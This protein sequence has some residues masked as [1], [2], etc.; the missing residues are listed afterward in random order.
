[1][2][3]EEGRR[4]G[5]TLAQGE[6]NEPVKHLCP[7]RRLGELPPHFPSFQSKLGG[8]DLCVKFIDGG[9]APEH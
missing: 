4:E 5:K 1:M 6:F 2:L 3:V 9:V 7:S 8:A